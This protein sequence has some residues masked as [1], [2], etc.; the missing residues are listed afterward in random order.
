M[1][2]EF[3]VADDTPLL[4]FLSNYLEYLF[5]L[6]GTVKRLIEYPEKMVII[7]LTKSYFED[8]WNGM[9]CVFIK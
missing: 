4:L 6:H 8:V 3:I 7:V 5:I 9:G 1:P 2:T